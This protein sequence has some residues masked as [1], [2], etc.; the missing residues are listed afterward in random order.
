M[1][2]ITGFVSRFHRLV[3]G[4]EHQWSYPYGITFDVG[5]RARTMEW[6]CNRCGRRERSRAA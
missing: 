6:M 5:G 4:C 1:A 3:H 2:T